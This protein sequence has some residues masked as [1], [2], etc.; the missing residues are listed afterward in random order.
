[1]EEED[2]PARATGAGAALTRG[3]RG[4]FPGADVR[5]RGLL[6]GVGL[7]APHARAVAAAALDRGLLVNDIGPDVLRL[8]PP[9]VITDGEIRLALSILQEV[10]DEVA[11]A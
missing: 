11:K 9:L 7:P 10:W 2:L 4:A 6:I 8:T 5:G 3:L 1:L